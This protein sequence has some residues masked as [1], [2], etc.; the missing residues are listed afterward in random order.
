[1]HTIGTAV[2][3]IFQLFFDQF[4]L[5]I[6]TVTSFFIFGIALIYMSI[7]DNEEEQDFDDKMQEIAK[8][9]IPEDE[10]QFKANQK[11][12]YEKEN[13]ETFNM[14][15]TESGNSEEDNNCNFVKT[16]GQSIVTKT[17]KML[18]FN[19]AIKII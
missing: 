10:R 1:M 17:H 4:W 12:V 15:S 13:F 6:I 7:T 14:G 19:Q 5:K 3:G 16:H 8:E 11:Q 9:M 18:A 2:G